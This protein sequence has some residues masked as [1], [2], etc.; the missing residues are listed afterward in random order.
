MTG[1]RRVVLVRVLQVLVAIALLGLWKLVVVSGV[2]GAFSVSGPLTVLNTLVSWF[3]SGTIWT[4]LAATLVVLLVGCGLGVAAGVLLGVAT[5]LSGVA[6]AY[7]GSFVA[8]GNA[9]PKLVLIPFFI[10]AFG[11]G[12]LPGLI[13]TGLSVV[14][15][16]AITIEAAVVQIGDKY[17]SHARLLGAGRLGLATSVFLPGI[18]VWIIATARL[19]VGI[20]FQAAV[21]SE[22]FGATRGLGYLIDHGEQTFNSAEIFS[23][24]VITA[25]L[26][27]AV[28]ALLGIVDTRISRR[29]GSA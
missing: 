4:H 20:A 23:G 6:R 11:F 19:S 21:V 8:F 10:I 14:F 27:Y 24:V 26:A 28:D 12:Q 9:I 22:F 1:R 13:I 29:I 17:V 3:T 7:V 2:L 25:A 5:A 15:L 18:G 16:T